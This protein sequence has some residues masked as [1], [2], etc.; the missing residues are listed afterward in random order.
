MGFGVPRNCL[1]LSQLAALLC[2]APGDDLLAGHTGRRCLWPELHHKHLCY[3]YAGVPD[4]QQLS[5]PPHGA[6]DPRVEWA[7]V[8]PYAPEY[9]REPRTAQEA[10]Q[11][12]DGPLLP[13]ED[14]P[15]SCHHRGDC[16]AQGEGDAPACSCDGFWAGEACADTEPGAMTCFNGCRGGSCEGGWCH[17]PKGRW[18]LGCARDRAF[19]SEDGA[20][21]PNPAALSIYVYDIPEN[22]LRPLGSRHRGVEDKPLYTADT[23]FLEALLADGEGQAHGWA[24]TQNPWAAA[25]FYMP[26]FAMQHASNTGDPA[27]PLAAAVRHVRAAAPFWNATH[28]RSHAAFLPG[29]RGACGLEAAPQPLQAP[30]KIVHFGQTPRRPYHPHYPHYRQATVACRSAQ[31]QHQQQHQN[32]QG[33]AGGEN[34]RRRIQAGRLK[35]SGRGG[36]GGG[37]SGSAAAPARAGI[38]GAVAGGH[39]SSHDDQPYAPYTMPAVDVAA[40][41][42]DEALAAAA[43]A[44]VRGGGAAEVRRFPVLP[45]FRLEDIAAELEG[46][47][48]PE[49]DV[50][51]P[52]HTASYWSD[53]ERYAQLW[54]PQGEGTSSPA[55]GEGAG[56]G[57]GRALQEQEAAAV[58]RRSDAP[59]RT[60]KLYFAGKDSPHATYSQGVRQAMHAMYGNPGNYSHAFGKHAKMSRPRA[61]PG[62]R[63][64][65]FVYWSV[66]QEDQV[67]QTLRSQFCLCPSG[68][69]WGRR[70]MES[71]LGGCVPVVVQDHIYQPL[72]DVVPYEEFS[73]RLPRSAL[74]SIGRA[75][76]DVS[77]QQLAELQRGVDRWHRAF[78]WPPATGGLAFNF[79]VRALRK[80]V[81][82]LWSEFY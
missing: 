5:D 81:H 31:H 15:D 4:Q 74:H 59:P 51:A 28:G 14:C 62:P 64:D 17:C 54:E 78:L 55:G 42:R 48:R 40:A 36:G 61:E 24:R 19:V 49:K 3:T 22:V 30:I 21:H 69:G 57:G 37:G 76:D 32:P 46:C 2:A 13:L 68:A 72:W 58:A 8:L 79:T 34:D 50:V 47:Y 9:A 52:T 11:E 45:G 43:A 56:S 66:E 29:D 20:W 67:N 39:C 70:V 38:G 53:R 82:N 18:G 25:L 41:L 80:R 16:L 10:E 12:M 63:P 65:F 33:N 26:I 44:E 6:A 77:P 1:C 75:L 23:H 7:V 73:L 71:M 60:I 27:L 35:A